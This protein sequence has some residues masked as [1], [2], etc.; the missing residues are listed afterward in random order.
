MRNLSIPDFVRFTSKTVG[1]EAHT[2]GLTE[3]GAAPVLSV[4]RGGRWVASFT[5][6]AMTAADAF[7]FRAWLH[8]LRGQAGSFLLAISEAVTGGPAVYTDATQFSDG[9]TFTDFLDT[10]FAIPA[11]AAGATSVTSPT[12]VAVGSIVEIYDGTS[13]QVVRVVSTS[14]TAPTITIGVR[15]PLRAAMSS[16]ALR[17]T[18]VSIPLRLVGEAPSV[19]I[20]PGGRSVPVTLDCEEAY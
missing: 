14:G 3:P 18:G 17:P 20:V 8:R 10:S 5:T 6:A 13:S 15:P 9:T 7:A 11:V 16:P 12:A 1:I 19:P 4:G 2:R